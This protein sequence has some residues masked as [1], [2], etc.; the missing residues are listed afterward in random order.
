MGYIEPKEQPILYA[1]VGTIAATPVSENGVTLI[2]DAT[3]VANVLT[4]YSDTDEVAFVGVI[5]AAVW[6]SLPGMGEWLEMGDIYQYDKQTVMVRQSHNRTIYAPEDTLAL[7]IV[8]RE[9]A[10]A[11]LEWV[12]GE[13]VN[14]GTRR[15]YK[16]VVYGCLQAHV[17]QSD[18]LPPNVPALWQMVQETPPVDEWAPWTAYAIGDHVT[19]LGVEYECRQS[20]TSQPGWNPP[21]VLALWLPRTS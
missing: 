19:Y 5:P 4:L 6:P 15:L 21:N 1:A 3:G 11:V 12:V 10:G 14:V 17:T 20:H 7:F 2:G 8:W 18:W 9:D 13:K 16:T